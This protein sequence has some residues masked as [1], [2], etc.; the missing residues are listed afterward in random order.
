MKITCDALRWLTI[1][2][3]YMYQQI[4]NICLLKGTVRFERVVIKKLLK[5]YV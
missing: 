4:I 5:Y 1:I 3:V 2:N